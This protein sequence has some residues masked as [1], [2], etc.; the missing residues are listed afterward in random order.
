MYGSSGVDSDDGGLGVGGLGVVVAV[1][2]PAAVV[3]IVVVVV[4]VVVVMC[5]VCRSACS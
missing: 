3:A 5:P 2:P 1:V 4:V